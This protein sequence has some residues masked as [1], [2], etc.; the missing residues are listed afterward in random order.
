MTVTRI[1]EDPRVTLPYSDEQ[2]NRIQALGHEIEEHLV[3]GDVRLTM[4]GEPTFVS[5]DD[6]V[7]DEW[8]TAAVGPTKRAYAYKLLRRLASR[9]GKGGVLHF[10]QGKWYPGEPLPRWAMTHYW[11][12]DGQPIWN[13]ERLLADTERNYGHTVEDARR[14]AVTL[15]IYLGV[16]SE[17]VI[18]GFEDAMYYMWR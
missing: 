16:Q 14:F 9:F 11:R 17:H 18:D 10:G 12:K 5:I 6:M 4:G 13:D 15:A 2:W 8:Q 3:R 1:H 7:G